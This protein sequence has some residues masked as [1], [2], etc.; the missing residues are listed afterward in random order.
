MSKKL[1]IA[2][3]RSKDEKSFRVIVKSNQVLDM[4]DIATGLEEAINI[5]EKY[6]KELLEEPRH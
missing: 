6:A 5:V 3:K 1:R 4:E 2:M